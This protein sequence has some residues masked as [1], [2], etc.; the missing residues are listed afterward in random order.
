MAQS[1][2]VSHG[3]PDDPVPLAP[4]TAPVP[5]YATGSLGDLLPTLVAGQ[6]VPGFAPGSP[7]SPPP[8]GTASS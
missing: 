2:A 3:W 7:N 4:E 8:T 6:E 5:E 1:A